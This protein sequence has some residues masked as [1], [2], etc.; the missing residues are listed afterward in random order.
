MALTLALSSQLP[1]A[2]ER[3]TGFGLGVD[4]A[5]NALC[6]VNLDSRTPLS[7]EVVCQSWSAVCEA[8]LSLAGQLWIMSAVAFFY[9]R[10]GDVALGDI[11]LV[12]I[13]HS[14]GALPSVNEV[15]SVSKHCR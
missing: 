4:C 8:V 3:E 9:S 6:F 5:V 1:D 10:H 11:G 13:L 2:I 14:S 15:I 7:V 12:P